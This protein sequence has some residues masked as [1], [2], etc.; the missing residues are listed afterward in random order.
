M[1]KRPYI[2]SL[3]IASL[4][5]G[6]SLFS[7]SA[8]EEPKRDPYVKTEA[9]ETAAA[10]HEITQIGILVEWIEMDARA[11]NKLVRKHAG[12]SGNAAMRDEVEK[13]IDAGE[14]TLLD[15]N[16]IKTRSEQRAKTESIDEV[17]YAT[18]GDPAEIPATL[19]VGEQSQKV[20]ASNPT[21]FQM[22]PAGRTV[23][24]DPI[25]SPDAST[26]DLNIAPE[27]VIFEGRDYYAREGD[28]ELRDQRPLAAQ[29]LHHE[30]HLSPLRTRWRADPVLAAAPQDRGQDGF[31]L[32][33]GEHRALD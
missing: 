14:A 12:A 22:R 17:I 24:V 5:G 10:E 21:A 7:T 11:A 20:T 30:G 16:Y 18:E 29:V 6:A 32:R 1:N 13:M 28:R 4:L 25:I 23:E 26:V 27:W 31:A 8:Q 2:T 19:T 15:T 3:S 9:K 33:A